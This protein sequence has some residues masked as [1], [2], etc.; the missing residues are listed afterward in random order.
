MTP[1][2]T[3][4]SADNRF[5]LSFTAEADG[6]GLRD[7]L[8]E[9]GISR[10][11]L[12]AVKYKGGEILV[13]GEE[14]TVRHDLRAGDVVTIIFPPEKPAEGLFPEEGELSVLYEDEALLIL[15]KPAGQATIPSR[16]APSGTLAN[17]VAGKFRTE[18]T[19]ATV[20]IVTRLDRETSGIVCIA[21]NRHIHHL[22]SE[23][24]KEGGVHKRYE[25][26]VR[27]SFSRQHVFIDEPI[28]RKEGSIIE[29]MVR[30]DGQRALTEVRVLETAGTPGEE[31]SR[32]SVILHTGRTHQI[33]VHLAHIGHPLE[34]DT[35]Y[36]GTT[37]RI[38]RQALHCVGLTF[39]HPL[40]DAPIEV[41]SPVPDDMLAV[42]GFRR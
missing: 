8:A 35:L 10:R 11:T 39:N 30:P 16:D 23:K 32:L 42:A 29:R 12:T 6:V 1:S 26:I 22:M 9:S 37:E 24:M 19:P 4:M 2:S 33:R 3:A 18:G 40:T 34:G 17:H 25:A 41:K 36:G 13:N 21:K 20:H 7:F 28:G 14:K 27:G 15:D 31:V 5:R 38:G